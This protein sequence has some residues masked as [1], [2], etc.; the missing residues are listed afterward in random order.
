M[1]TANEVGTRQ[2]STEELGKVES[3]TDVLDLWASQGVQVEKASDYGHGFV[4]ADQQSL[5][6]ITFALVQ[7]GFHASEFDKASEYVLAFVITERGDKLLI[8]DGSTTGVNAQ[9]RRIS[10]RRLADGGAHPYQGLIC[11]GGLVRSDYT[12]TDEMGKETP[13]KTYYLAGA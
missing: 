13:A 11:E 9:L 1:T 4:P 8:S 6:G 10:D 7:W 5:V 3:F 2:F 12:Y